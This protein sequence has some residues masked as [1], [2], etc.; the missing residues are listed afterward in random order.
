MRQEMLAQIALL[1]R[2]P[3]V[4]R[5]L[6]RAHIAFRVDAQHQFMIRCMSRRLRQMPRTVYQWELPDGRR[7]G[8]YIDVGTQKLMSM[9][10]NGV[11]H[12]KVI[13]YYLTGEIRTRSLYVDGKRHGD[14]IKYDRSGTALRRK[15]YAYGARQI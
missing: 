11:Q 12:G 14:H 13:L 1:A 10:V 4:F 8:L 2:N 5:R 6:Q 7:D 15:V 3:S 9:K